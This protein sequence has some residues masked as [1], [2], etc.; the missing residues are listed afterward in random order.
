MVDLQGGTEVDSGIREVHMGG[1]GRGK[2]L[3]G[4]M[5]VIEQLN[6]FIA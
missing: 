1:T 3:E 4:E 6:L 2:G 5:N